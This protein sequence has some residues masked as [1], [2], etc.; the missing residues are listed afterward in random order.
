MNILILGHK[1]HGKTTVAAMIEEY[2]G[3]PFE[4]SSMAA[5]RVFMFEKLKKKYKYNTISE[6][7]SD[8]RNRRQ[9]WF[10]EIS[11]FNKDDA[12]ALAK[13]IL[14]YSDIYVGMRSER[15]V[16][17]CKEQGL[18]DLIIGVFDPNKPLESGSMDV[19]IHSECDFL[20]ITGGTIPELELK[21]I[22]ICQVITSNKL[23][24]LAGQKIIRDY[25]DMAAR[26]EI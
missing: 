1:E 9:E 3:I 19:D 4:D 25:D 2:T 26:L 16:K 23:N 20:I 15:E 22:K 12:A 5:A 14:T 8:R 21:I 13:E 7:H 11:E 18:F 24:S 6:C 10:D 17:A